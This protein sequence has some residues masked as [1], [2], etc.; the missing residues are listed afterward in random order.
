ME[1]QW[2]GY[3]A[4]LLSHE[5]ETCKDISYLFPVLEEVM[6]TDYT[7]LEGPP[8]ANSTLHVATPKI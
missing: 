6:F 1:I 7:E 2:H 4:Y 8:N 3:S 5:K